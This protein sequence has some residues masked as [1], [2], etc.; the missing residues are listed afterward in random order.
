MFRDIFRKRSRTHQIDEEFEAHL[1]L[2]SELLHERGLSREQAEVHARR[3]FGNRSLLAEQTREVWIWMWL[4][5]LLQDLRYAARTLL[6]T[7]AFTAAAVLSLALGIGAGTAVY[8]IADTVF[9]RP[10]PYAHPEQ[11]LWVT[12]QFPKRD[13][14]FVGSPDYV[15]WRRDNHAFQQL[16]AT[17]AMGGQTML[18]NGEN[19]AE[20]YDVRV[21]ANFLAALGIRPALGGD[22]LAADEV[23]N[24]PRTVLLSDHLWKQRFHRDLNIVGKVI[25]LDGD[26]YTVRGI[27]PASFEFPTDAKVDVLTTLPVSTTLSYSDRSVAVWAVYGRLKPGVSIAKARADL[28]PLF[29]RSKAGMPMLFRAGTR[30]VLEPL[31]QHRIGNA[32]TLLL[33]L[34]G[35]VTCLLLIACANVSNLLLARWSGR[36]GELA[37]RAAI[38]AGRARIARQL[39][40]EAA[41]LSFLGCLLGSLIAFAVL[42]GFVHYA[43]DELPRMREIGLDARVFAIGLFVSVAATLLFGGLPALRAGRLDIQTALQSGRFGVAMGYRLA[44][45]GLVIAEVALCMLLLCGGALLLETLWHLR[46]DHL[47]FEPE[48]VLAVSIPL[49]GTKLEGANRDALVTELLDFVRRIPGTEGAAQTECTPL[50][51]GPVSATFSRSDRPLPEAFHAGDGIHLCGVDGEYAKAAGLR[52]VRGRFFSETDFDHPNTL[53]V[54]NETAARTFF[55]GEDAIGKQILGNRHGEEWK[56]VIGIVSDSKNLGLD[57]PASPQALLNGPVYPEGT[58]SQLIVRSIGDQHALEAAV[59][60]KL[61]SIDAGLTADFQ[62]LDD[63]IGNMS[64]GP[65]FNAILV[66][67]FAVIALIMAVVGVY[68]VL[69]FTVAQRTQEIG[70]RIALGGEP[71]RIF[72]FIVWEGIGPVF[73]GIAGGLALVLGATRYVKAVL[74]GVSA[75]DPITFMSVTLGLVLAALIAISIPARR[76]A[77]VDPMIALRHN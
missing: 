76:A 68:G 73:I 5:R 58:E 18:L 24:A 56:T 9:V 23:P 21:S 6:R 19:A 31:Q 75:T 59:L 51:T 39:L 71:R 38:G 61:R 67:G 11:L 14:E 27:L 57:A 49:K 70:I 17:Q 1:A 47:G 52:I 64:A 10:L 50:S 8:S 33:L 37:I 65:R 45:Q 72:R 4:D 74:Y 46:N 2:E 20:V 7:P 28:E 26:P 16:A 13:L 43:G 25:R 63:V 32:R 60:S 35:A 53:A 69:A 48:H 22:F 15:A 66:G 54:I 77:A 44:K 62:S 29:E 40:T 12:V 41:L 55:P 34:I 30:L 36:S 42:R 3:S